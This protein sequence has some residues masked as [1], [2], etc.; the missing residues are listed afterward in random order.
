MG[1][2]NSD[3]DRT[4]DDSDRSGDDPER[5]GHDPESL[6]AG[7][8]DPPREYGPVPLWWWD[9]DELDDDRLTEQLEDLA[10]GGITGVCFI[11]KYPH[12]PE[13]DQARY[14]SEEWWD[15][16]E[17][18]ASECA[19][20]DVD[21]WVHDETYH[22]SPPT[23]RE[24]WQDALRTEATENPEL[25]GR[26][27]DRVVQDVAEG[28]T[29][30]L[31]FPPEFT[32]LSVAAYP[33]GEDGLV[34]SEAVDLDV[35][36]GKVEWTAPESEVDETAP[37]SEVE[38]T[39]KADEYHVAAVGHRPEGLCY[40]SEAAAER[41]L[42]LHFEE[43]VR[44]LGED[45]VRDVLAGTFEDELVVL[46][47]EVPCDERVI[48]RFRADHGYDPVPHLI[49]LYEE[50]AEETGIRTAYYDTVTSLL[51]ECWFEPLHEFHEEYDLLR[52][53]DNWGRNDLAAGTEQ[54]GD[55]YRTMRWYGAPGY[56]DGGPGAIGE[57]NFFDAK[58]SASIAACYD[59][60]RVWGELFHSTGWGFSPDDQLAGVVENVCYGCTLYDQHGLYYTTLGGWWEHAPGDFHFRQP[61]W[62]HVGALN[63]AAR[64][65][66]YLFSRGD[67]VVDAAVLVPSATLHADWHP[68]AGVGDRGNRADAV[69]R[70]VAESLYVDGIDPLLVDPDSLADATIQDGGL[71]IAGP[72]IPVL[73]LPATTAIERST[74]E[75][76]RE[77]Y[78]AG[79]VVV[80]VDR[81]P[82]RAVGQGDADLDATLEHVFGD[83]YVAAKHVI[84]GPAINEGG[85]RGIGVLADAGTDLPDLLWDLIDPDVWAPPDIYHAHNRIGDRDAYLLF[86]ARNEARRL[87]VRLSA[88]GTPERWDPLSGEVET[89]HEYEREDGGTRLELD[90]AP[91]GFEL[92]VLGPGEA[93]ATRTV[94]NT[95]SPDAERI[96]VDDG[97]TFEPVPTADNG[98]GDF[99]YP[100]SDSRIGPEVRQFEYRR[101]RPGE[102]GRRGEWF[103][104]G[105]DDDGWA[106]VEPS[107]GPYFWRHTGGSVAPSPPDRSTLADSGDGWQPYEFSKR[108]GRPGTH[109][110]LLGYASMVS[111]DFLVSPEGGTTYF[112]TTVRAP[113]TGMA[114]I[115]YGPGIR[116]IE[117]G[118]RTIEGGHGAG[119][120]GVTTDAAAL[121]GGRTIVHLPAGETAVLLAVEGGVET[122]FAVEPVDEDA[123]DRETRYAPRLP[124]FAGDDPYTLDYAPWEDSPVGWYRFE[125]PVGT[126]AFRLPVRGEAGVWVDGE[127]HPIENGRVATDA[128]D[129]SRTVA[130][131]V[132]LESGAYGGAAWTAPVEVETEPTTVETGRWEDLGL[133]SYSGM[134]RYRRTVEVPDLAPGD[135]V[136]LELGDVGVSAAVRVNGTRVGVAFSRPF[137]VDVTDAVDPGENEVEVEVAN[138]LANHFAAETPARYV[139]ESPLTGA[140]GEN[141]ELLAN[142]ATDRTVSGLL[143]PVALRVERAVEVRDG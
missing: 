36:D 4:E 24:Y 70:E 95:S 72:S 31:D 130:V 93:A 132:D 105:L 90:V 20:L 12:G 141:A 119:A 49:G 92:V 62:D 64:R 37:E 109:P 42:E 120:G 51:E 81:L 2:A 5:V 59:R 32:P 17:H 103:R 3:S 112:W 126:A 85:D 125:I 14:F 8:A 46:D 50:C 9:G 39:T 7:F 22:H 41:Y 83:A 82:A 23:W 25:R 67:R 55:Y 94:E 38:E 52:A 47:G 137:E 26:V 89:V 108:T 127:R 78:D 133:A 33:R 131:R 48:D 135:R 61:Y 102:D 134:G 1:R 35:T 74:L 84:D 97:W 66:S 86:N 116:R 10:A 75:T 79:G 69:T 68:E 124:W 128:G 91:H 123:R 27:L 18:V 73:V 53:H 56:D 54:Y 11:S 100:P 99:R 45:L 30:T 34:L 104:P 136:V 117:L 106:S 114:A 28:E 118:E 110:Y 101:E 40:T 96:D 63:D 122:H 44:R 121:G 71:D 19:R 115:Q 98:R 107:H 58:L 113:E 77:L 65:L 138:T 16:M 15:H 57:R 43:Y 21:L 6:D 129:T 13:G 143:G 80:A 88:G 140:G 111:E 76:V 60:D 142:A 87:D 139:R 29:A